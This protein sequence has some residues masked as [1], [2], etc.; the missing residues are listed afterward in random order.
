MRS[1]LIV[2]VPVVALTL[3]GCSW[4]ESKTGIGGASDSSAQA[5]PAP[6]TDMSGSSDAPRAAQNQEPTPA[7]S[8]GPAAAPAS[9]TAQSGSTQAKG[10]HHHMAASHA[11]REAQQKLKDDGEYNGKIDGLAGPQTHQ[12]LMAFQQKNN[13]KQ[14]GHLDRETREKLGLIGAS[15]GSSMPSENGNAANGGSAT[16]GPTASSHG[17]SSTPSGNAGTMSPAGNSGA[18]PTSG[19]PASNGQQ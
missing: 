18:G 15:S 1:A 9:N 2:G 7:P 11:V 14:T 17:G 13:L 8:G 6:A 5:Q 4:I 12:A 16:G 10:G 19:A 3:G